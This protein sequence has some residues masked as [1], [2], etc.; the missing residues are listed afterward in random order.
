MIYLGSID[1]SRALVYL[2]GIDHRILVPSVPVMGGW[3]NDCCS[4]NGGSVHD[5]GVARQ[6]GPGAAVPLVGVMMMVMA[7]QN[8]IFGIRW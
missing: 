6:L 2:D 7:M 8:M 4:H 5:L 3:N 1:D